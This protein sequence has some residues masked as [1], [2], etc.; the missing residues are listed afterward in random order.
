[1]GQNQNSKLSGAFRKLGRVQEL[2]VGTALVILILILGFST[3]HF[4]DVNNLVSIVRSSAFIGIMALG[5]VFVLSERDVDLSVGGIYNLAGIFTAFLLTQNFPLI[6]AILGG[7]VVGVLCGLFNIGLSLAFN[8]PTIIITLGTMSVLRGLGLVLC[9]ARPFYEF[10]KNNWFFEIV[11]VNIGSVP[12]PV[13]IMVILTIILF[14]V[15]GFTVFGTR[16]RAIGAN[17]DAA[18]FTGINISRTRIYV[19]MLMGALSAIAGI[20]EVAYLQTSSPAM[21]TGFELKVIAAAIIGGTALSGG[22][23]SIIG[24]IIGTLLISTITNGIVQLGVSA[25]WTSTVTG[26]VIIAAVAVDYLFKRARKT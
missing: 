26:F 19:F 4:F 9:Q 3:E 2:G 15:Y 10:D 24:A 17:P 23:G 8:I 22:F 5:M 11:G 18:R 1:M 16:V 20:L 21:G 12:T 6:V 13:I 7:I 25:Y 14:I